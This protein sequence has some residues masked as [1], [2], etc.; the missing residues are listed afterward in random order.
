MDQNYKVIVFLDVNLYLLYDTDCGFVL[1]LILL[2]KSLLTIKTTSDIYTSQIH[3]MWCYVYK[4]C[5][6]GSLTDSKMITLLK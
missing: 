3:D 4:N 6:R 5:Q 2:D 1:P